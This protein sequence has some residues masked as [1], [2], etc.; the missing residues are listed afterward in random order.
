MSGPSEPVYKKATDIETQTLVIVPRPRDVSDGGDEEYQRE[1]ESLKGSSMGQ[2]SQNGLTTP[3]EFYE[4]ENET[5]IA[6]PTQLEGSGSSPSRPAELMMES[7][8]LKTLDKFVSAP[9]TPDSI[10]MEMSVR[11]ETPFSSLL[12]GAN[13]GVTSPVPSVGGA[14]LTSGG[15]GQDGNFYSAVTSPASERFAFAS[16]PAS[17]RSSP[18]L[19]D[20]PSVEEMD[21]LKQMLQD[22]Q[23][24]V[25]ELEIQASS[26]R[27]KLY[28]R[29]LALKN[30]VDETQRTSGV[31]AKSEELVRKL[32]HCVKHELPVLRDNC[33]KLQDCVSVE[34]GRFNDGLNSLMADFQRISDTVRLSLEQEKQVEVKAAVDKLQV[35]HSKEIETMHRKLRDLTETLEATKSELEQ[36]QE[37]LTLKA[38]E[39]GSIRDNCTEEVGA[40]KS[41]MESE[42]KETI[43]ALRM[44][45]AM[46][47]SDLE[48]DNQEKKKLI[49]ELTVSKETELKDLQERLTADKLESVNA[50]QEEWEVRHRQE[51]N[52][53]E[54]T[55]QDTQLKEL[56]EFQQ[57]HQLKLDAACQD[58]TTKMESEKELELEALRT[59]FRKVQET[60]TKLEEEHK[61]EVTK[62]S[63]EHKMEVDNLKE[64]IAIS[65]AD[66]KRM[67][68]EQSLKVSQMEESFIT[69]KSSSTLRLVEEERKQHQEQ[70]Q[71]L[72]DELDRERNTAVADALDA[73]NDVHA[74]EMEEVMKNSTDSPTSSV[75]YDSRKTIDT[76]EMQVSFNVAI[77]KV[78]AEKDKKIEELKK[79]EAKLREEQSRNKGEKL[80]IQISDNKCCTRQ[81][82]KLS[83]G[84][85]SA[86]S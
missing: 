77:N 54:R 19:M 56:S 65:K 83:N 69:E 20:R 73:A 47:L 58:V 27:E 75:Y 40:I 85:Y 8:D 86:G 71:R 59:E 45:L 82:E 84:K 41:R 57:T 25:A 60:L 18:T 2:P 61:E 46:E 7:L 24:K 26:I 9:N 37:A 78:A 13:G 30:A 32:E 12:P 21:R 17:Y 44:E 35:A 53:V 63:K 11:G 48:T 29:E 23:L 51:M 49:D 31:L 70:M 10:T 6:T 66:H 16:N 64:D 42:Q 79:R 81:E 5:P 68:D 80:Y 14:S 22:R 50:I 15:G 76:A 3:D 62:L 72:R 33:A 36:T 39:V 28:E 74:Q 38:M 34:K 4:D 1:F 67:L 52:N 55:L 43:S